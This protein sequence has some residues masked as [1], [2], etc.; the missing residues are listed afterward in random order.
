M[1]QHVTL[2]S[3]NPSRG[4]EVIGQVKASTG[5]EVAA[6]VVQARTAQK[7]WRAFGVEKRIEKLRVLLD[8]IKANASVFA[9]KTS[10]EMGQII[11]F[12]HVQ[13]AYAS[14]LFEWNLNNAPD[15]L[16][17]EITHE[18]EKEINMVIHE[19]YGVGVCIMA[20]NFPLPNFVYSVIQALIAGNTMVVKYSEEIPLF[21]K[22]MEE[23]CGKAGLD[24]IVNFVFG[25]G[26]VGK[27][28]IRQ[29]IDFITFTGSYA[30]GEYIYKTA[31]EKFIPVVLELGGSSPGVVF[32]DADLEKVAGNIYDRRFVNCGQ[33]CSNLKRLIVHNSLKEELIEKLVRIA[34]S[35]KIGDAL[36]ADTDMGPLVAERQVIKLEEQVKDALDKG[37]KLH[38]GGKRPDGLRGAYY[39]PTILS[40]I[41][42]DMRVWREE[43]FG[44]ALPVIGFD[45]YEEAIELA[46]DTQ[47]G[48]TAYV[49][50][51]DNDLALKAMGEIKAGVLS[52]NIST[53][54]R[55][56]NPFG[57]HKHSGLGRE[58]GKHGFFDVTQTKLITW[59]K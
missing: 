52:A 40:N 42:K 24:G 33:F 45:T 46:N 54:A 21:A 51:R 7:D 10:I 1:P 41:S 4:Y 44:P 16:K 31:A 53:S 37:A 36:F 6:K 29:D 9:E 5:E 28:L 19:P 34:K 35:K 38:H 12:S 49:Y 59:E 23:I 47:Y 15:I 14:S 50:T 13:G 22:Y 3:T 32:S 18:C 57:G 43:V 27:K 17:N 30:T 20:W 48:L 58:N 25:N 8:L 55:C 26:E 39:E 2:V 11:N 56:Q